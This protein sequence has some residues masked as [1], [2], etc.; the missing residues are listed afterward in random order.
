[1]NKLVA[2]TAD[3]LV[4]HEILGSLVD[5]VE[6][7]LAGH[8]RIGVYSLDPVLLLTV[9][10]W[11]RFRDVDLVLFRDSFTAEYVQEKTSDLSL[12][13]II[14]GTSGEPKVAVIRQSPRPSDVIRGRLGIFTSGTTGFPKLAWH[15]WSALQEP[16]NHVPK[17][18]I[19][20]RWLLSYGITSYAG[21]QVLFSALNNDGEVVFPPISLL[22]HPRIISANK[23]EIISATPTYWRMLLGNWPSDLEKPHLLQATL[24]GEIVRQDIL[25]LVKNAFCP[26]KITHIYASTEAG[27]ALV[28][29]DGLEGFPVSELERQEPIQLRIRDGHLEISTRCGMTG[30]A[31]HESDMNRWFRTPDLVEQ[32]GNRVYFLGRDDGVLNVGGY[33]VNPE[34]VEA[35]LQSLPG[36]RDS[37]VYGRANAI[38]GVLVCAEVVLQPG[39]KTTVAEL[40]SQL[41]ARLSP[42]QMPR[43]V[44]LTDRIVVSETGKKI[45]RFDG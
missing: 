11:A 33:K 37:W 16:S 43:L 14:S 38:S 4:T 32:R 1:M 39:C 27:T 9:L 44:K 34:T 2:R 40:K 29:S 5:R 22:D 3:C 42:A 24:G 28:V 15:S 6:E 36:V 23:I 7:L 8:S 20:K 13:V 35:E 17:R 21:L 19:G 25:N 30:Y 10:S 26:Q 41:K 31:G 12:Q 45:R 18:L